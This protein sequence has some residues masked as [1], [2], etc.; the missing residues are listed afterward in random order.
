MLDGAVRRDQR[1]R[2]RFRHHQVGLQSKFVSDTIAQVWQLETRL[3]PLITVRK[4]P[5]EV[6]IY[7][8]DAVRVVSI[9]IDFELL[10]WTDYD[11]G[12]LRATCK[13]G[14]IFGNE[15]IYFN[16]RGRVG[17]S[18]YAEAGES[19]D[20]RSRTSSEGPLN[21][22]SVPSRFCRPST[23][24]CW[25]SP[26]CQWNPMRGFPGLVTL[27]ERSTTRSEKAVLVIW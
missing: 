10:T 27:S 13:Q 21:R 24:A 8:F 5:V 26:P 7:H 25:L 17:A 16:S 22:V 18:K 23:L 14:T 6:C 12:A 2:H 15:K 20:R 19:K 11:F 3:S 1:S 4:P 9:V